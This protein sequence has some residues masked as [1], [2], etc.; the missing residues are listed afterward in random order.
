MLRVSRNKPRD[1][2][3][4]WAILVL[5][6]TLMVA[7]AGRPL[8]PPRP[9]AAPDEPMPRI[10]IQDFV[11][12]PRDEVELFVWQ[13][14]D[15]S[16]TA[17]VNPAG[18]VSFP[19]VGSLKATGLTVDELAKGVRERLTTYLLK[20]EVTVTVKSARSQKVF[21][22]GEVNK[23]GVFPIE[24]QMRAAEAV[25]LAGG[26]NQDAEAETVMLIRGDLQKPELYTIAMARTLYEGRRGENVVLQPGDILYVP[27]QRI[28]ES[29]RF[30]KRLYNIILPIVS[31]A[32]GLIY[33]SR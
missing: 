10:E 25:A 14:T 20:P 15:L 17:V 4:A 2:R 26:F 22:L 28:A 21:V 30:F 31:P 9:V 29:E 13:H 5:A 32:W 16:R 1:L 12:G 11:L 19:L 24:G 23:P 6:M 3:W 7:C 18:Y 8:P 33:L 27:A